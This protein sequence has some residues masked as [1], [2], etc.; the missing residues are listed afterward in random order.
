MKKRLSRLL[1][2]AYETCEN[3]DYLWSLKQQLFDKFDLDTVSSTSAITIKLE[4]GLELIKQFK[5]YFPNMWNY[6]LCHL[7]MST[8]QY[9]LPPT[10]ESANHI[11]FHYQDLSAIPKFRILLNQLLNYKWNRIPLPSNILCNEEKNESGLTTLSDYVMK[12]VT[13]SRLG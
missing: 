12:S 11:I 1:D 5:Q 10:I 6:E 3:I 2:V 13:K 8:V 9:G 4:E 7:I